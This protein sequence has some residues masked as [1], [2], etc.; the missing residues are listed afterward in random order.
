MIT[1]ILVLQIDVLT[2][3]PQK[4]ISNQTRVLRFVL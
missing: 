1:V 4:I 2:C 3:L